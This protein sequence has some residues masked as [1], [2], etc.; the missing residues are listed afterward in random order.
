VIVTVEAEETAHGGH[1]RS[2][3][4]F[5]AS[6]LQEENCGTIV[7]NAWKLSMNVRLGNVAGAVHDVAADLIDWSKNVLGDLEK[8]IK[9]VKKGLEAFRMRHHTQ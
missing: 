3:F 6:W 4:R 5:E 7:E 9:H 1:G 2:C 8:R